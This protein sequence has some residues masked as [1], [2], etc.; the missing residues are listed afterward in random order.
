MRLPA[1]VAVHAGLLLPCPQLT[2]L[3][4]SPASGPAPL[5][6]TFQTAVVDA[7][8]VTGPYQWDFGDGSTAQTTTASTSH[9]YQS[10]GAYT[11][12]VT[13]SGPPG[14][15]VTKASAMVTVAPAGGA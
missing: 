10:P 1:R 13:A 4:A 6:V 11:V 15:P 14:C 2:G 3:T 8:A 12:T 9:T 7:Q 5:A